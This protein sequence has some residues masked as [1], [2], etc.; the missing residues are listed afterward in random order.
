M[1]RIRTN[2]LD[3]IAEIDADKGGRGLIYWLKDSFNT[4][5]AKLNQHIDRIS[6]LDSE[7][8]ARSIIELIA[9]RVSETWNGIFETDRKSER[10]S[11]TQSCLL[12]MNGSSRCPSRRRRC[13]TSKWSQRFA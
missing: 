4:M 7:D 10:R 2:W 12:W 5:D 1:P 8:H 9:A 6:E 3:D 13:P 11:T